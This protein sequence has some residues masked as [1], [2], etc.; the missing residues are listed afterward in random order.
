[1]LLNGDCLDLLKTIPDTSVDMVLSD[2]P[3]GTTACKWDTRIP[4][5]PLWG[6]LHRVCKP[7]SA[8]CM[9]GSEPFSSLMRM[10]NLKRFKYDWVWVKSRPSGHVHSKNKPMK[11]HELISI[12]SGGVTI[13]KG[14]SENRMC[15]FPQGLKTLEKPIKQK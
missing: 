2:L 10:S 6:Q 14:Q 8:M 9:F 15:Y 13:H 7:N 1:M 5:E 12:F 11:K 3:Y 4:F